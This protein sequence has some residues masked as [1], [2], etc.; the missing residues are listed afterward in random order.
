MNKPVKIQGLIEA[1]D[2]QMDGVQSFLDT[3]SG[4]V[5][6]FSTEELSAAEE[7][8]DLNDFPEW[9]HESIREAGALLDSEPG[10]FLA[11]PDKFE[12]DEYRIMEEFCWSISDPAISEYFAGIIRGRG[13]FRRF[14]DAANRYGLM[15]AWFDY[16]ENEFR[17]KAIAWCEDH[18][19]PYE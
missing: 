15:Q 1:M 19:L 18:D 17:R 7:E 11:L 9:M 2:M 8:R 16:R 13:A 12:I 5:V 6:Q 3:R 4:A 14:K 10:T